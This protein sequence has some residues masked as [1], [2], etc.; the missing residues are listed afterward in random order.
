M[1]TLRFGLPTFGT[2]R[3]ATPAPHSGWARSTPPERKGSRW[4]L[5]VG[6]LG[7]A[8]TL[9][10]WAAVRTVPW[11]GPLVADSLR[12]VVGG[13]HVTELEEAVASVEDHVEHVTSDGKARSLEDA[14]PAALLTTTATETGRVP[15]SAPKDIAPL[16]ASVAAPDDGVWRSVATRAGASSVFSRTMLHPDAER[17]YAELFVFALDLSKFEVHA[18]AGSVEPKSDR[19]LPDVER[20]GVVP[21]ADRERL[22]AAFNG[23]FKAEHGEF[24]MMVSGTELLRPK[25]LSCTIAGSENGGL[26]I[27]TWSQ[28]AEP[29]DGYAWWRQT[30]GCM[31]ENGVLHPGLRSEDTKNWG[32][33]LDG[34]TVIRRSALGL[35]ADGRT[36]FV[37][38]SNSTTAR[39]MALGMQRAGANTVAQL[40]VNFSF[41]RFLVYEPDAKTGA[42]T[43]IGAVKGLLYT[44]GR[45]PRPRLGPRFLLR[46]GALSEKVTFSVAPATCAPVRRRTSG[47]RRGRRI[48]SRGRTNT[49]LP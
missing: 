41:P 19:A 12:A 39:A 29:T 35:S 24:G 2:H 45:V 48:R 13:E 22:V 17:A 30:P 36:L 21:E 31:L 49:P 26:S 38:I 40:D 27:G 18:V 32:A 15:F 47:A 1:S 25:P 10:G 43:A 4:L 37:G 11:F 20:P 5:A 6:V 3:T 9:G 42:L 7:A 44:P 34:N 23:G 46:H 16:Y 28:L 33:T 14:T 8:A